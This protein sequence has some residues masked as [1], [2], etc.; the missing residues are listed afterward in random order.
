MF[1]FL[2]PFATQK[3]CQQLPANTVGLFQ[4]G[5]FSF[6]SRIHKEGLTALK[7]RAH[8]IISINEDTH[9]RHFE[10]LSGWPAN[11]M[12]LH[13]LLQVSYML[14]PFIQSL[15]WFPDGANTALTEAI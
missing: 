2:S 13:H 4:V 11:M 1:S 8:Y 12:A 3:E 14:K 6:H 15:L 10:K 7:S 5:I 9:L